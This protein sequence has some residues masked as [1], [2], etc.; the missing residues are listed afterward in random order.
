[1]TP[2]GY[3]RLFEAIDPVIYGEAGLFADVVAG[4]PLDLSR[5]DS[6]DAVNA[7]S[8]LTIV[9]SRDHRVYARHLLDPPA[10]RPGH[11]QINPL[12]NVATQGANLYLRLQFPN[13]D[14][15]DEYGACKQYLPDETVIDRSA[16]ETLQRG[17]PSAPLDDLIRR[18][19]IVKLPDRYY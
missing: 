2:A 12:Y 11:Y 10:S 7:D 17:G 18:R 14:Y 9:A 1:L 4:G 3:L 5:L 8:A 15:E 6:R 16:L 19:V 13:P